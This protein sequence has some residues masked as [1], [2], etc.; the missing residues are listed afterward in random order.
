MQKNHPKSS[1]LRQTKICMAVAAVVTAAALPAYAVAQSEPAQW[2]KE[3]TARLKEI[4]TS[5][6]AV[7]SDLQKA[8]ATQK[9][10]KRM[11]EQM[12]AAIDVMDSEGKRGDRGLALEF[13]SASVGS[14]LAK[15]DDASISSDGVAKKAELA[16]LKTKI[17]GARQ[18]TR[19][20]QA[21]AYDALEAEIRKHVAFAKVSADAV[22]PLQRSA[23]LWA[24]KNA[25]VQGATT[26][27][28]LTAL[29]NTRQLDAT[30]P[31]AETHGARLTWHDKHL[32]NFMA[33]DAATDTHAAMM[34]DTTL[35][36]T[37]AAGKSSDAIHGLTG[38]TRDVGTLYVAEG[39]DH[40]VLVAGKALTVHRAIEGAGDLS[41][42]VGAGGT[43]SFAEQAANQTG[44]IKADN[45]TLSATGAGGKIQF[46]EGTSA[47][48]ATIAL[49]DG[50]ELTFGKNANAG[51][52]KI[53]VGMEVT[54]GDVTAALKADP[55]SQLAAVAAGKLT[56]SEAS[57]GDATVLNFGV[58]SFD[59]SKLENLA[60]MNAGKT[61]I[62]N[63]S[64]GGN[65]EVVNLEG[66]A[67]DIVDTKLENM[68]LTNAGDVTMSGA[69][70]AGGATIHLAGG[71]LDV[72][73][74]E[75]PGAEPSD[76]AIKS[77]TIGSLAGRGD[78]IAGETTIRL[79]ALNQDDVFD[80][81]ILSVKAKVKVDAGDEAT[82]G[83]E[84]TVATQGTNEK[85]LALAAAALSEPADQTAPQPIDLQVV[86]V[87]SGN[88]TLT[89][90]Q[91]AIKR[92]EIEAGTLTA[93]HANALGAGTLSIAKT[94]TVALST[95]VSGVTHVKNAGALH[96]D[97][98][99]LTVQTYS[100]EAGAKIKS[101]VEKVEGEIVGGQIHV[102]QIGDFS[103]T[104]LEVAVADDIEVSDLL[105]NFQVVT[106]EEDAA[107]L[108]GE[109]TV[110]SITGGKQP[111][112]TTKDPKD[113]AI[114]PG[115]ETKITEKNLVKFL[116]ADGGYSANEQAVLA[117]VDGVA[118]G[119]LASGKIGGKVLS[120]MAL[121]T[122]GSD[123]QRRSARLLSGESLVNNATAAQGSA[124]SFQRG[125][126]TRMIA[127]G[128]MFDD[129][130]ANGAMASDNGI[131][132]WASFKGGNAS[133]RGDGMSFEVKGLDGAIGIDKRVAQNTLVGA[134]VGLGNQESKAKGMPGESKVNS[135]SV[136]LY[137]SHLAATN[138]F[139]NGGVSY[140][141]HSVKTDRTVAARNASAR[142]SGKT[143][144]QTFGMFGEVGKRFGVSGVNIDP[145]VGVRVASTR[146]NAFD[147][148]NRDGQ[149]TDGLKVG[150]QSQTSTRGVVG[151]RLWS[152]VASIAGGK[153]APSLRL[154]YEH[155]FGN[156]QSSLTNAIY[157]APSQFTVK[158][159][160]LGR[161]IFTADL[162]VDM[163]IKKQLEVRLGGNVSVRKGE[164]ALG[165]GIS[166]K[167]RF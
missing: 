53:T 125:M 161:D 32:T 39:A 72:S 113:P 66:A 88:L 165:G 35:E 124:T 104:K 25:R 143:S 20:A 23:D 128:S 7:A 5:A 71:A 117:S 130:T 31:N 26:E 42:S 21:E 119:D 55:K 152:E 74:I 1:A 19:V 73:G 14:I 2:Q 136:G 146:L 116:A 33:A 43:L 48:S 158:G 121:Q 87:G 126:Q 108:G 107:V 16:A 81:R 111:E 89:N 65:A 115:I 78:V 156:T 118:L 10:A 129:T 60:L 6:N 132:G 28:A 70:L 109:V 18:A 90:D 12:E 46:N 15:T 134:S 112:P 135:V 164:S 97:T 160:K 95:D 105:G 102:T 145:S 139:V 154:S 45:V 30:T 137:G 127:G 77:V 47:G 120:A 153:V 41:I 24:L 68:K 140:T 50:G 22:T 80:G 151:V 37:S 69:T 3:Q 57:T 86:K 94:G 29:K 141:N 114:E 133:Q 144:G 98:N 155:E 148:T 38:A 52:S 4:E 82:D 131:A 61:T 99:K 93:A 149:G 100:S 122:A 11:A 106:S 58:A 8:I 162:G 67:L 91:S 9:F 103:N 54:D 36:I 59:K 159:P 34:A 62:I 79:G 147:E 27:A 167:Y 49:N 40:D 110:G 150:S 17:D 83:A 101:R 157:G 13:V 163:Q 56:V 84:T 166:A 92:M 63:Q 51:N 76:P 123:E 75:L 85:P 142:L 138:W 96:L 44:G 64:E